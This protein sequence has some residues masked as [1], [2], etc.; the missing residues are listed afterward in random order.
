MDYTSLKKQ[1]YELG[2][3]KLFFEDTRRSY[4]NAY[5][6][7]WNEDYEVYGVF[8]ADTEKM[9]WE[10]LNRFEYEE[11]ALDYLSSKLTKVVGL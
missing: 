8:V 2:E 5:Y 7:A 9:K 6:L 11:D 10:I 1:R 3:Q 4:R